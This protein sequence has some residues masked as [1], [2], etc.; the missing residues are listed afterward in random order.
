MET[1]E[2]TPTLTVFEKPSLQDQII[3]AAVGSVVTIV[4]TVVISAGADL[5]SKSLDRRRAKKLAKLQTETE[6]TE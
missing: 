5:L 4:A 1:N 6:E 3:T 2:T